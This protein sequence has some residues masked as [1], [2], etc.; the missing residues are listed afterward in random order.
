MSCPIPSIRI[1][2]DPSDARGSIDAAFHRDE[3]VVIAVDDQGGYLEFFERLD[4]AAVSQHG[5][6]LTCCAF[7]MKGPVEHF[8]GSLSNP[9]FV[10]WKAGASDKF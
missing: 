10:E 2:V 6:E 4:A 3:C 7:R 1:K 5:C 9:Y 8:S